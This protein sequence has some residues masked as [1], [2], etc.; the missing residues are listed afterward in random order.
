MKKK[1]VL[2][3][4]AALC[5]FVASC[6]K[7]DNNPVEEPVVE[8]PKGSFVIVATSGEA[9]YLLQADDLKSGEMTIVNSGLETDN[10]TEWEFNSGKYLYRLQYNQGNAG[11]SSSY[12]LNAAGQIEERSIAVEIRSR[13][14]THGSYGKYIVTAAAGATDTKDAAENV[15]QG[16]TFTYIDAEAQTLATKTVVTENFLGNGEYVTFSG[17]A[18]MDGKLFTAVCPLGVSAYGAANGA[19]EVH[20]GTAFH[21]NVW[22]AVFDNTNFT[23]PRIISD[24]RLSYATTR[25]RSQYYSNI[26][27]DDRRNLYVFSSA[28]DSETTKPSG[29]LRIK[30]GTET[31]DPSFFFNIEEAAGGR[32]LYKVFYITEDY[33][34]LQLYTEAGKPASVTSSDANRL[35]VFD[36]ANKTLRWVTG[37]PG[38]DNIGSFAKK[39]VADK[40]IIYV[41]VVPVDAEGSQPAIYAIDPVTA[42]ATRGMAVTCNSIGATGKLLIPEQ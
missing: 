18:D 13:F 28:Y 34:L 3:F 14:T 33:F 27:T 1:L 36:A 35:A 11:T 20:S 30:A 23:N 9:S 40:G 22:I 32:H 21:D 19:G 29:V 26:V 10:G 12:V 39:F 16:V 31:F 25:F 42:T 5:L 6:D 38:E 41:P 15:A 24:N 7:D 37:L 4:L 2:S 8:E 17:I